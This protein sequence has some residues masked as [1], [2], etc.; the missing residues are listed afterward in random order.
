[1]A[2]F[3]MSEVQDLARDL[4]HTHENAQQGARH[5]VSQ[6]AGRVVAQWKRN[7]REIDLPHGKRYAETI[8]YD[9]PVR[10][11]ES[12]IATVGPD[13]SMPQG[14]MGRGFEYGSINQDSPHMEGN[15]A[16]DDEEGHFARNCEDFGRNVLWAGIRK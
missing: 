15:R 6:S 3:D 14:G 12:W 11:G 9:G 2:D 1:M 4:G 7:I 5:P 16:A 10:L 13:S 8:G